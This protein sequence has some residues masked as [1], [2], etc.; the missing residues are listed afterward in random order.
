MK[1]V[2]IR[3]PVE[4]TA[5]V[6][7]IFTPNDATELM[8]EGMGHSEE[9]VGL[10]VGTLKLPPHDMVLEKS[11]VDRNKEKVLD[12]EETH[13]GQNSESDIDSD[14]NENNEAL[15][16][17]AQV[18]L[19]VEIRSVAGEDE[20]VKYKGTIKDGE[21]V[22]NNELLAKLYKAAKHYVGLDGDVHSVKVIQIEGVIQG[23]ITQN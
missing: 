15:K 4:F 3:E 6:S 20:L 9:F 14:K 13:A 10:F 5:P 21:V 22:L 11:A 19:D 7:G 2:Q 18:N 17:N 1:W 16:I 23:V 12:F 8:L